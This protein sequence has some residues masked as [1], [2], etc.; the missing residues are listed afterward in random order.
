MKI[1]ISPLC[2]VLMLV[3][4]PALASLDFTLQHKAMPADGL[5][6][7][8]VYISDGQ[9]RIFVRPPANWKM[10]NDAQ[11]LEFL[12]APTNSRV[13][14]EAYSGPKALTVDQ[15]GARD[16]QQMATVQLPA[17]AKAPVPLPPELNPLPLFGWHTM[18]VAFRYT[19]FGQ[20]MRRSVMYLSMIPGRTVQLTV[21]APE[22]DYDKIEKQARQFMSSWFEPTRDLPPELL[23]KYEAPEPGT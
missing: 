19:Y 6:L 11:A 14:V 10:Y 9:S 20:P 18:Q 15:A 7:D 16:L 5:S 17:E 12:P 13:R 21:I 22:A 2:A 4:A 3:A 8:Q 23:K 1:F